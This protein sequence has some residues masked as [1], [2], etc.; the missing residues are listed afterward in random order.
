ML[1]SYMNYNNYWRSFSEWEDDNHRS[2]LW[3]I[4]NSYIDIDLPEDN[5]HPK[6]KN[7]KIDKDIEEPSVE[8]NEFISEFTVKE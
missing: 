6:R 4:L 2:Q 5:D 8:L 7:R 3:E 1:P